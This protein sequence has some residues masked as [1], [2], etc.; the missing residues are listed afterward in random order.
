MAERQK[1]DPTPDFTGHT[2]EEIRAGM[3]QQ[4]ERAVLTVMREVKSAQEWAEALGAKDAV[5]DLSLVLGRVKQA[6]GKASVNIEVR[7]A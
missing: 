5:Q 6:A 2:P 4:F 7:D 3:R 1:M